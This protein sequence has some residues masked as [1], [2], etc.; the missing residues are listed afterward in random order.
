MGAPANARSIARLR[1][2]A[3]LYARSWLGPVLAGA[4]LYAEGIWCWALPVFGF[5]VI[6]VLEA[7]VPP[8][9]S[10][11]NETEVALALREPLFDILLYLMVP[12][13]WGLTF[14]YAWRIV[15][16]DQPI[17]DV[18]GRILTMGTLCGV[19]G[20]NVAHELGHR[21]KRG[22]RIMARMLLVPALYTHFI[23][24]H[25]HGHH[26]H[27]GTPRDPASA[28]FGEPLPYFWFRSI[29]GSFRSAWAIERARLERIGIATWSARNGVL[30]GLA[31]EASFLSIVLLLF[32]P[33][34]LLAVLAEAL[35]GILLLETINYIEHYGLQRAEKPG[36]GYVRVQHVHSW[37]SDHVLG[38][39]V[40]FEL[41]RHSDHHYKAS[42]K[43]QALNT[44]PEAPQLPAGYPAMVLLALVPPLW[45]RVMDPRVRAA[46]AGSPACDIALP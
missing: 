29:V 1:V 24:E 42:L 15:Q 46:V 5:V 3:L 6:P 33:M 13:F 44:H 28:R 32:G 37:N 36:G 25:N 35:L 4:G 8:D 20:I 43:Y 22:E 9:R 23:V 11:L 39:V 12:M 2:R 21:V 30:A 14:W 34:A 18:M 19:Y 40:L 7:V 17:I 26:R 45:R 10:G 31:W 16:P 27:V 41:T 38:R